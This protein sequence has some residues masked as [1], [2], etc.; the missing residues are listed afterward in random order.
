MDVSAAATGRAR[1]LVVLALASVYLVW[2]STYLG[3]R[4]AIESFPPLI[5]VGIRFFVAGVLLYGYLRLR[6]APA[7]TAAQWR[8]SVVVGSML[9]AGGTGGVAFA[10]QWVASGVAALMIALVPLLTVLFGALW[11]HRP[12]RLEWL[13]I[14]VGFAGVG[15]LNLG[16]N[17]RSSPIGALV[18]LL[19][20]TSWSFGSMWSKRLP[21]PAGLMSSAAQMLAGGVLLLILGTALGE[22]MHGWPTFRAVGALVY[23]VVFGS[24]VGFSSYLYLLNTVRP[25]LATSY[26]YVNPLVAVALGVLLAGERVSFVELLAMP[27]IAAGVLLVMAHR[28]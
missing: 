11:D 4:I 6:G 5:M 23:L 25:A 7:P 13:G 14:A 12:S 21:L 3:M 27:V 8:S 18:L 26:A 1:T 24:F 10:E 16:G 17:L 28:S 9:L 20:A 19:A 2:G 15:L 22:H